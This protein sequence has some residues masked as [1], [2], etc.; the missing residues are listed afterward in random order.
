MRIGVDT[1]TQD[2]EIWC[3]GISNGEKRTATRDWKPMLERIAASGAIPVFHNSKFDMEY[4]EKEGGPKFRE[5][6]DTI[7]EAH[8]LGYAPLALKELAPVFLGEE[9]DKSFVSQRKTIRYEDNADAVL[10]GCSK[11]AWATVALNG[12]FE[13]QLSRYE[14]IYRRER[15]LTPVI[16]DMERRGLPLSPEKLI[17]ARREVIRR[18]GQLEVGLYGDGI[19]EPGNREAIAQKFWSRKNRVV[20]TPSGKLSTKADVLREHATAEERPWVDDVILWRQLDKFL[21]LAPETRV[22][23]ADLRWVA[24]STVQVGDML[25][26][27]DEEAA[28]NG[29]RR[30]R[31]TRV[32]A[33]KATCLES[34]RV[35]TSDGRRFV[36]SGEHPWLARESYVGNAYKWTLTSNLKPGWILEDIG[37]PWE[38]GNDWE[39]GWLSGF[40]DGE[41]SISDTQIT[42]SQNEG[43]VLERV[44]TL[45]R[46][47]NMPYTSS[48]NRNCMNLTI[49]NRADQLR[50]LGSVR[51]IRLLQKETWIGHSMPRRLPVVTVVD[52]E[53]VGKQALIGM[54]TSTKTFM[55]E[56]FLSH[57]STYLDNWKGHDTLHPNFN[58]TGTINWRFSCSDPNVQN[59]SKSSIVPLYTLFEAGEGHTFLSA[60]Y[61]QVELR[62]LA[63][64]TQ[65]PAMLTAYLKEGLDMHQATVNKLRLEERFAGQGSPEYVK[66]KARRYAK[67]VN[68]GIAYGITPYGLAPRLGCSE[69]E[70]AELIAAFYHTYDTILRW[71]Q[72][73]VEHAIDY[74]YVETFCGRPLYTPAIHAGEGRLYSHAEKQCANLPVSG[75]AVEIVKDAMIRCDEY[76]VSQVHDEVL[77]RVPDKYV[78]EYKV[79]LE[80]TLVDTRHDVLYTIEVHAGQT[81]GEIKNIEDIWSTDDADDED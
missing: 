46:A 8:L 27:A 13:P 12:I 34:Y 38:T 18:M 61:S 72:E 32:E 17:R 60:D 16:R 53:P 23:T 44:K 39:T 81:W 15:A 6:R 9:L 10:A 7:I 42:L 40:A 66:D 75:G 2:D 22:L 37:R 76:L 11:D 33:L 50:F 47:Q 62:V 19:P 1:E 25:V 30:L 56:G 63:N 71:Q 57:N 48:K 49:S 68:F 20:N 45:L 69:E 26:G 78:P 77:Y 73:Q 54:Q 14:D 52:V 5:W 43:P 74:G 65:D 59:V 51:P 64:V 67:T 58:P 80:E 28:G 29:Y 24:L 4:I 3:A 79:F 55:A 31:K 36:A 35:T 41:G 70:A 21:C